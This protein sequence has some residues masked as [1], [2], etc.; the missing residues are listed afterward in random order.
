M[1]STKNFIS[2]HVRVS[3]EQYTLTA[4]QGQR[5][6]FI[7][8]LELSHVYFYTPAQGE[9]KKSWKIINSGTLDSYLKVFHN[10]CNNAPVLRS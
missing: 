3:V 10:S 6:F 7:L 5:F 1:D 9:G 4:S 2:V 8:L